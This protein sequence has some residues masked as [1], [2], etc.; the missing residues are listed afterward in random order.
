[1]DTIR[2]LVATLQ[3]A[4]RCGDLRGHVRSFLQVATGRVKASDCIVLNH[5]NKSKR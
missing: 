3:D 5:Q 1:M 2:E 4:K